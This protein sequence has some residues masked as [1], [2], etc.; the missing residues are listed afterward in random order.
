MIL[1]ADT[2]QVFGAIFTGSATF[3]GAYAIYL[4]RKAANKSA[5]KEEVQQA[6][7]LQDVM[8]GHFKED[9]EYL[10]GRVNELH[11]RVSTIA[12][13]LNI[14]TLN[15]Q[16]CENNLLATRQQL[17]AAVERLTIAEG[18]LLTINKRETD[19]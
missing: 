9:N 12:G 10:R 13:E 1:A 5:T 8:L 14:M 11:T 7:D 2:V 3:I 15:H 18:Q 6:F 19:E 4:Q 16:Q 17:G